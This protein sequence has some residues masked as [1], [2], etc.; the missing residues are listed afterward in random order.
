MGFHWAAIGT[1]VTTG[2]GAVGAWIGVRQRRIDRQRPDWTDFEQNWGRFKGQGVRDAYGSDQDLVRCTITN[3][4]DGRAYAVKISSSS[5]WVNPASWPVVESGEKLTFMLRFT[6]T[7]P[8][9]A[10]LFTWQQPPHRRKVRRK[11]LH[12]RNSE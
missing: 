12:V 7:S 6:G 3:T 9:A 8:E 1:L 4:G 11:V 2:V 10:L 5:A